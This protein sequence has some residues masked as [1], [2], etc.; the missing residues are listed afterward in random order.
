MKTEM[1]GRK[2]LQELIE[3][4]GLLSCTQCGKCSSV[5]TMTDIFDDFAYSWAPRNVIEDVLSERDVLQGPRIW[6]CL[7][8]EVC[9]YT[10]PSGVQFRQFILSLRALAARLKGPEYLRRCKS[11]GALLEPAHTLKYVRR[12][13]GRYTPDSTLLCNR[14]KKRIIMGR[15]KDNLRMSKKVVSEWRKGGQKK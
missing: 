4:H 13:T 15:F 5:C 10:C 7:A 14:C 8:C 12:R 3:R 9:E 11:C 1:E 2:A 6:N